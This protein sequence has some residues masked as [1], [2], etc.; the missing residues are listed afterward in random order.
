MGWGGEVTAW[1]PL[2]LARPF[3]VGGIQRVGEALR[4]SFPGG[5]N[6]LRKGQEMRRPQQR[7]GGGGGGVEQGTAMPR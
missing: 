2:L 4:V 6:S 5:R 3:R 7:A 1:V